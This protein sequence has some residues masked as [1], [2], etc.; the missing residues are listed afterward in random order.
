MKKFLIILSV[1]ALIVFVFWGFPILKCEY[2]TMR[3]GHEFD[4]GQ[5]LKEDTMLGEMEWFKILSYNDEAAEI[6][7]IDEGFATGNILTFKK[8]SGKWKYEKWAKL[9]WTTLGGT[10]DEFVWPY[11]WHRFMYF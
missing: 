1:I 5:V 4:F 6:Y 3:H 8:V 9:A 2:L 11:L 10:A 7:Y